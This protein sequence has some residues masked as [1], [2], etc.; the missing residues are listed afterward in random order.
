MLTV[1]FVDDD[2]I[3]EAVKRESNNSLLIYSAAV[4]QWSNFN[5]TVLSTKKTKEILFSL[6]SSSQH[7]QRLSDIPP[8]EINGTHNYPTCNNEQIFESKHRF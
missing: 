3:C 6:S 1:K 8:A 4:L 7:S 5:R 2:I